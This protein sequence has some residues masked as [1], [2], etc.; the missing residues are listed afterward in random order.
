[1]YV[2]DVG[3]THD[4]LAFAVS[5][6]ATKL[7]N[8]DFMEGYWIARDPAFECKNG[9]RTPYT[10]SQPQDVEHGAARD[11]LDV[12][13]LSLRTHIKQAFRMLLEEFGTLWSPIRDS[14]PRVPRVLGAGM[15]THNVWCREQLSLHQEDN[16]FG[17]ARRM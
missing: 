15:R 16:V 17:R 14:L 1:M 8:G 13:Q 6:F 12:L 9:I 3:A 7:A 11:G 5:D 10:E 2:R 4:S